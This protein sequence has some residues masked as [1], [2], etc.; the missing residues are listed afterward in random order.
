MSVGA[1]VMTGGVAE[2][3]DDGYVDVIGK[4]GEGDVMARLRRARVN[5]VSSKAYAAGI[6]KGNALV[7]V[8]APFAPMGAARNA[9]KVLNRTKSIKVDLASEEDY[10]RE[11]PHIETRSRVLPPGSYYMSNPHRSF[12]HGHILGRNPIIHSKPRTSAIS[13]GGYMSRFFWPMKLV[14]RPKEGTSAI[15]GGWLVSS[16]FGIP[17][18]FGTWAPRDDIKTIL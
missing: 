17:T 13:G 4:D 5:A 16:M 14:S 7:V 10:I 6:A 2:G 9:I 11:Q 1:V 15:R 12:S 18:L 3:H 8:R